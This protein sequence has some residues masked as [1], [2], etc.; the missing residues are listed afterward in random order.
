[1]RLEDLHTDTVVRG[2]L[3]DAVVTVA[4]VEWHGSEALTLVYRAPLSRKL[5]K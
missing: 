4:A 3:P 2:I 5:R 1:L